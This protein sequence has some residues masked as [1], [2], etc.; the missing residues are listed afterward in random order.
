M[1]DSVVKLDRL[2][3]VV[4]GKICYSGK[5]VEVAGWGGI[6]TSAPHWEDLPPFLAPTQVPLGC[7]EVQ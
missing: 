7:Y 5:A 3:S 2:K 1:M 6:C 4:E